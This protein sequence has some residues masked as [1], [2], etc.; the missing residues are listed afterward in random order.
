MVST[1][2]CIQ[3]LEPFQVQLQWKY[4]NYTWPDEETYKSAVK[5]KSY[6]QRNN[7]VSGV[8]IYKDRI[9]LSTPRWLNGVPV[10]LNSIPANS[11][12][13]NASPI[14]EPFPNWDMQRIGD[15]R[16]FQF[17][18]TM[19]VDPQG[20]MWIIDSGR[21]S[22]ITLKPKALCPPKLIILDLNNGGSMLLNYTFPADVADPKTTYLDDIVV[23]HE[24]GGYAY[25]TDTDFKQPGLIVFSLKD[26]KS[27]KI[28]HKSMNPE[29][30]ASLFFVNWYPVP[31][32]FPING[33][34]LS[35]ASTE[36]DR[37][38]YYTALSSFKVYQVPTKALKNPGLKDNI[39]QFIEVLGHK[40][41]Q[42]D[43]MVMS[44]TGILFLGQLSKNSVL[45]WD[46]K[47]NACFS[48]GQRVEF[49]D[50]HLM[51][52]QDCFTFNDAK[53]HLWFTTNRL[54]QYLPTVIGIPLQSVK[55]T[56]FRLISAEMGMKNYQY[57]ADGTSPKL[58]DIPPGSS[59]N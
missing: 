53:G 46:S 18:Q 48:V 13:I 45:K 33:I 26:L 42:T 1:W 58:P 39:D 24:D 34:A 43:G 9:Y 38:V 6:I 21:I 10:A 28:S 51:Q 37:T 55:E 32:P 36:N 3:A 31:I 52:W 44:N 15:C 22:L 20:R 12:D 16:S 56:N 23:D 14:L 35:P 5:N 25:I 4:I 11:V 41:S 57:Y 49:H 7:V 17:V 30:K 19:E 59:A 2:V 29:L 50:R 47:K 54:Q 40:P 8:R 27:W